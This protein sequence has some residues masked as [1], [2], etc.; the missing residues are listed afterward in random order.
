MLIVAFVGKNSFNLVVYFV[1]INLT[2]KAF[3][4]FRLIFYRV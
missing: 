4:K 2:F 3:F 1:Q